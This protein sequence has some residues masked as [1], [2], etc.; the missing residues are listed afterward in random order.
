MTSQRDLRGNFV[1]VFLWS[2]NAY[3]KKAA[4]NVLSRILAY[5]FKRRKFPSEWSFNEAIWRWEL[6]NVC[7]R[8][9]E[10]NLISSSS[11]TDII[12]CRIYNFIITSLSNTHK[13]DAA[14]FWNEP[15]HLSITLTLLCIKET[16][17]S[18]TSACSFLC[19]CQ[20]EPSVLWN[21]SLEYWSYLENWL[22]FPAMDT[23]Y[24]WK[25]IRKIMSCYW[26]GLSL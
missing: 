24:K 12:N 10:K 26:K 7:L 22:K 4:G 11:E 20:I 21:Q 8:F 13:L 2:R 23:R 3:T 9:D 1:V 5:Y 19:L 14:G 6:L 18:L 16:T 17:L 25:E 15:T